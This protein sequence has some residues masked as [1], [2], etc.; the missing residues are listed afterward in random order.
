MTHT[1]HEIQDSRVRMTETCLVE[2]IYQNKLG[3]N[4]AKLSSNWNWASL[5]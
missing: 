5:E 1:V 3:L 4:W 2:R